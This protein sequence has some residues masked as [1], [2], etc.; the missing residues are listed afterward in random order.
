MNWRVEFAPEV[1]PDVTAA[2]DWYEARQP[3]LGA[4]FVEEIIRVWDALSEN[5]L[6]NCCRHPVKNIRWRY[7]DRF[8]YRVIYE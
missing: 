2:A 8:P 4:R 7:P 1:E 5:P 3:G 6:L